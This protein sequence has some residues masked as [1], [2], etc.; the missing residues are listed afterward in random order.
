MYVR[1]IELHDGDELFCSVDIFDTKVC[2][3]QRIKL[4]KGFEIAMQW[5]TVDDTYAIVSRIVKSNPDKRWWQFWVKQEILGYILRI[6][7]EN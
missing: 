6:V 3:G 7:K 5:S 2:L 1:A 4:N